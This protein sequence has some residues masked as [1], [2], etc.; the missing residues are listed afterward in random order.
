VKRL[1]AL[2]EGDVSRILTRAIR[3][4]HENQWEFDDVVR[5]LHCTEA[6][7]TMGI[8]LAKAL[9]DVPGKKRSVALLPLL[10]SLPWATEVLQEWENDPDTDEKARKYLQKQRREAK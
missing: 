5:C 1:A 3:K 4:G 8:Q 9:Y 7:P 2:G 6:H 10:K